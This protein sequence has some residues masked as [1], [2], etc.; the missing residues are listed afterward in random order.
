MTIGIRHRTALVAF[1]GLSMLAVP[2]LAGEEKLRRG[3]LPS[4]VRKAVD[5]K[6]PEAKFRGAAKE[7]EDGKT[8]YEVE[9]TIEGRAVDAILSPEGK[10]LEVEREVPAAKLP[11]AVAKALAAKYPGAKIEKAETIT[12]GEDGP[13]RYEVAIKGTEVVL[14]PEGRVVTPD[15][16]DDEKPSA[17]AGSKKDKEDDEDDD[18]R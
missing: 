15:A 11:A 6:F 14:T 16:E 8:T 4:A 17:K 18:D 1:A 12:K 3:D 13:V 2:A 10:I 7:V 5:R 9:M